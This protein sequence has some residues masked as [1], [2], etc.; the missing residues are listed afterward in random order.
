ME[1]DR[2]H[3]PSVPTAVLQNYQRSPHPMPFS[4]PQRLAAATNRQRRVAGGDRPAQNTSAGG[5]MLSGYALIDVGP[6][7]FVHAAS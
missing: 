2:L 4:P 6:S 5:G 1:F 7:E 3:P